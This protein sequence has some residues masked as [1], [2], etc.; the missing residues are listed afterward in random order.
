[1]SN[2]ILKYLDEAQFKKIGLD[3]K[4]DPDSGELVARSHQFLFQNAEVGIGVYINDVMETVGVS[5]VD[6]RTSQ[7]HTVVEPMRCFYRHP[8]LLASVIL[9]L[10]QDGEKV[11]MEIKRLMSARQGGAKR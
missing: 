1:M 8:D 4:Y 9:E 7:G 2:E 11:R 6:I 10:Q 3:E 5:T